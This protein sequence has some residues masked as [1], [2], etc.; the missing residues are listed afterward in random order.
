MTQS[1]FVSGAQTRGAPWPP[2]VLLANAEHRGTSVA[3]FQARES[4]IPAS[5]VERSLPRDWKTRDTRRS[6]GADR[7]ATDVLSPSVAA[8]VSKR[9]PS[10]GLLSRLRAAHRART[11]LPGRPPPLP[12]SSLSIASPREDFGMSQFKG[13]WQDCTVDV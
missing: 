7:V 4:R 12:L 9:T 8:A 11:G 13:S 1:A 10:L 5:V 2:R 6:D 3:G